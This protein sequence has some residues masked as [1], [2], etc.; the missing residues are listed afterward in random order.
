M[1]RTLSSLFLCL[2]LLSSCSNKEQDAEA[3]RQQRLEAADA[4]DRKHQEEVERLKKQ[5]ETPAAQEE[6]ATDTSSSTEPET[7]PEP[8]KI[9]AVIIDHS[10]AGTCLCNQLTACGVTFWSCKDGKVRA[11]QHDVIYTVVN[12]E[13]PADFEGCSGFEETK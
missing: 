9:Q 10:T 13:K 6:S 1:T 2:A 3:Q 11:C 7:A 4:E 5:A 8:E 12:V